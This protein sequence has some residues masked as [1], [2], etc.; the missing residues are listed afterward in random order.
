[1]VKQRGFTLIEVM[2][3]LSI[4]AL[5]ALAALAVATQHIASTQILEER[6]Y[7][8]WVASNQL[9]QV[10]VDTAHGEWPPRNNRRGEVEL[11]NQ[12]W[13]WRSSVLET[14]TP[15]LR[16]VTIEVRAI[17]DGPVLAEISTFVGRR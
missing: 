2:V 17:E 13:F 12:Q 15:D 14:V 4:F 3:A 10:S 16:E 6:Y 7:A 11:A 5:G 9:A 1:M 8:Q